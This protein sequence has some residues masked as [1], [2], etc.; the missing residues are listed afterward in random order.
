MGEILSSS[1][2]NED[3]K[4]EKLLKVYT[5]LNMEEE[6]LNRLQKPN[7][8]KTARS[9]VRACY[10]PSVRMNF[11]PEDLEPDFRYA[12]HGKFLLFF[13]LIYKKIFVFQIMY[14]YFMEW[15]V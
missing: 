1:G 2:E 14:K 7:G 13:Y 9:I 12:I 6:Q 11:D 5:R 4:G 8:T 10:P 15:K 3:N